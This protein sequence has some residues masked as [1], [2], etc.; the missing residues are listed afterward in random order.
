MTVS[1]SDAGSGEI[2]LPSRAVFEKIGPQSRPIGMVFAD[3]SFLVFYEVV[4]F[5]Y[6][7]ETDTE[8]KIYRLSY[9]YHYQRPEDHFYFR[10]DHHPDVGD[11]HTHPLYHLHSAGWLEGATKLQDGPRYEMSEIT[12]VKVLRLILVTYPSITSMR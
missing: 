6:Q 2:F 3:G 7:H 4:R 8:P 11:P 1:I 9:S 5:G 12:L 10:F